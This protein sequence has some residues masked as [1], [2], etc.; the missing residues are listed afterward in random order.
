MARIAQ[1]AEKNPAVAVT[2]VGI[3]DYAIAGLAHL[4][5][6]GSLGISLDE[7]GLGYSAI[8]SKTALMLALTF[9]LSAAGLAFTVFVVLFFIPPLCKVSVQVSDTVQ[10]VAEHGEVP[11]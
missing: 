9:L 2:L 11:A 7:V 4:Y 10:I 5:L 8:L 3:I 6:Y 1:F